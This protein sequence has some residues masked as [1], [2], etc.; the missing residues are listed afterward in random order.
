MNTGVAAL[1][2]QAWGATAVSACLAVTVEAQLAAIVC[3]EGNQ[4]S[5]EEE[6]GPT[7]LRADLNCPVGIWGT[8][9]T[10]FRPG[11]SPAI[12]TRVYSPGWDSLD[13]TDH[14]G[15]APEEYL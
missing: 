15:L 6:V 3:G 14:Q 13:N 5:M 7:H 4:V 9:H 11:G 2:A 1:V 12:M 8:R 10:S